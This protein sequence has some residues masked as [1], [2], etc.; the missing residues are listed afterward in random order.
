MIGSGPIFTFCTFMIASD[1]AERN[2][3]IN[4]IKLEIINHEK[5]G[6]ANP[7]L[8]PRCLNRRSSMLTDTVIHKLY[9]FL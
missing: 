5:N 3:V 2:Y 1:G 6:Q 7:T 4:K 8:E 9:V